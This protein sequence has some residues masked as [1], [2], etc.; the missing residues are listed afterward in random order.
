M[1][2]DDD[3][4]AKVLARLRARVNRLETL[5]AASP[6]HPSIQ[7]TSTS[8]SSITHPAVLEAHRPVPRARRPRQRQHASG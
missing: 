7:D 1:A 4:R 2:K 6:S 8:P 3:A 5:L